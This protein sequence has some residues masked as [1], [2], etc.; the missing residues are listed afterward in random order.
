MSNEA[1]FTK[2]PWSV[3]RQ[4]GTYCGLE[5]ELISVV[6]ASFD[7][8][9]CSSVST[10]ED[11]HLI[12]AAPELYELVIDLRDYYDSKMIECEQDDNEY[13]AEQY[14][15]QLERVEL[16]LARARGEQ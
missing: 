5:Y 13:V 1:K 14:R 8:E 16:I 11:A 12:T 3:N 10:I 15:E 9:I 2:G 6:S 7:I 4:A